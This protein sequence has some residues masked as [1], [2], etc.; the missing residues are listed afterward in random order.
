MQ[1]TAAAVATAAATSTTS[2]RPKRYLLK[3]VATSKPWAAAG[4]VA[5]L[6]VFVNDELSRIATDLFQSTLQ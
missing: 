3:T 6:M 5:M 4:A 1:E 2:N